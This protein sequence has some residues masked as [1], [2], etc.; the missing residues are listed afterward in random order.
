MTRP[1]AG[2]DPLLTLN[3]ENG[4]VT[5]AEEVPAPAQMVQ[6]LAGF[7]ISQAP[8]VVAKLGV[9]TALAGGPR[10][11]DQLAAATGAHADVLRRIIRTL[12]AVGVFRTDGEMVEA[13]P[14]A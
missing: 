7:Q 11:I 10:A 12:A 5:T 1:A 3:R 9:S 6:L 13:T 8:Y 2:L 4:V 14:S